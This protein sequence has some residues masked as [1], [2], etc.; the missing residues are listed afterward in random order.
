MNDYITKALAL[1]CFRCLHVWLPR[2]GHFE[3]GELEEENTKLLR[4]TRPTRCP[5]CNSQ[6][7]DKPKRGN[8]SAE[9]TE[10]ILKRLGEKNEQ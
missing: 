3:A 9:I 10:Q 1:K 4:D 6:Y 7:W 8:G 5:R 2:N